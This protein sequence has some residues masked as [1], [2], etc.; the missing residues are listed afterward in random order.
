M[1]TKK[2]NPSAGYMVFY[3]MEK[4][5]LEGAEGYFY[6]TLE[7]LKEA[8]KAD[9][10]NSIEAEEIAVFNLGKRIAVSI[11]IEVK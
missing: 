11:S 6:P 9:L 7:G 2:Q 3:A 10:L 4:T 8:I 5:P 1:A